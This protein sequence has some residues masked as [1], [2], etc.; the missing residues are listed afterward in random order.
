MPVAGGK[1]SPA[2]GTSNDQ[3]R[4]RGP[5]S[6]KILGMSKDP[7]LADLVS[8]W[9]ADGQLERSRR[10]LEQGR[11]FA[12]W[13]TDALNATWVVT[14]RAARGVPEDAGRED[15]LGDLRCEFDLRGIKPPMH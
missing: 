11:R 12:D 10:Y 5:C 2:P 13:T 4:G 3:M 7:T 15:E 8:A 6:S 1:G 9:L 14:Y